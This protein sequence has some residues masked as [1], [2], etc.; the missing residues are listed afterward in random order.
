LR[1]YSYLGAKVRNGNGGAHSRGERQGR[2]RQQGS[3]SRID[4]FSG[5]LKRSFPRMNAG[6]PPIKTKALLHENSNLGATVRASVGDGLDS[7]DATLKGGATKPA[8]RG[9]SCG[10]LALEGMRGL[11]A[12]DGLVVESARYPGQIFLAARSVRSLWRSFVCIR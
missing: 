3:A 5:A 2:L 11:G 6:L 12:G 9:K 1:F 7:K 4:L 10:A 8:E